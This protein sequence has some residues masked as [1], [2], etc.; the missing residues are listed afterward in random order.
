MSCSLVS[1]TW[2]P[3]ARYYLFSS[4][5]VPVDERDDLD[6][7][8]T[9]LK[10]SPHINPYIRALK[11]TPT[12]A[13]ALARY[14]LYPLS[15]IF[16]IV[17]T[18]LELESLSLGFSTISSWDTILPHGL[19][20][21]K[22]LHHLSIVGMNF[23]ARTLHLLLSRYPVSR[24]FNFSSNKI[25]YNVNAFGDYLDIPLQMGG[26][27][28]LTTH[29][30]PSDPTAPSSDLL[31][32]NEAQLE[33][34]DVTVLGQAHQ[35]RLLGDF[36]RKKGAR[37]T[38]L[39]IDFHAL[40][41]RLTQVPTW[42]TL[43]H[44]PTLH[45]LHLIIFSSVSSDMLDTI[46]HWTCCISLIS[47]AKL[48]QRVKIGMQSRTMKPPMVPAYPFPWKQLDAALCSLDELKLVRFEIVEDNGE[49]LPDRT[50]PLTDEW[51]SAVRENLPEAISKGII[52]P[53]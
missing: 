45:Y 40:L 6:S 8:Q 32:P 29:F 53:I 48:V 33:T 44:C 38:S 42:M 13:D 14:H 37:I 43:E 18:L 2:L 27:S 24:S 9:F 11:I 34:L 31:V 39:R 36:L 35:F 30:R 26:Y 41:S 21:V 3:S 4:I 46:D 1:P 23:S 52:H 7:F 5:H 10:L 19:P 20:H 50:L 15:T 22:P 49:G 47:S 25:F 16:E 17:G 12:E 51:V 28:S